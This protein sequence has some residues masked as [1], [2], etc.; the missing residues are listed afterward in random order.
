MMAPKP[1]AFNEASHMRIHY[2]TDQ[3]TKIHAY[4]QV[5][6]EFVK[7]Y[8]QCTYFVRFLVLTARKGTIKTPLQIVFIFFVKKKIFF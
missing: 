5:V 1:L 8:P 3:T 2:I 4:Q 7:L 6:Y